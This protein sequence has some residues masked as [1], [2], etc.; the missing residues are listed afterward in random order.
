MNSPLVITAALVGAEVTRADNP[1]LPMTAE[2]I[3]QAAAEACEA[4]ASIIHLHVRSPDGLPTQDAEAFRQAMESIRARCDAIIQVSTGGAVGMSAEERLQPLYLK[5]EMASLTPG[6]VNFGHGVFMNPW[7][8]IELFARTMQELRVKPE[9]EIFDAGMVANA[10]QL[11]KLGLITEPL[12]FNLVLGVP[13]GLPASA[14]N[15]VYLVD[16]LPF[17]STWSVAGIGRTQTAMAM[18]AM[19]MGGHVRV[20][21]EDNVYYRRGE[22]AQSNAQLVARIARLAA[23]LGRPV[24]T[25][26]QA[27]QMLGLLRGG[28][29]GP[30]S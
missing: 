15:L 24:A 17:G 3:G 25:P 12:H 28:E 23:E 13:G 21:F 16:S 18:I 2:E 27:R 14:R 6:S 1:N 5:P 7:P 29:N 26:H 4:G 9:L 10:L 19:A 22:L 20:G 11:R 8:L 30:R